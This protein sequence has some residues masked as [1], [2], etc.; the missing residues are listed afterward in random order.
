MFWKKEKARPQLKAAPELTSASPPSPVEPPE[1]SRVVFET[2]LDRA[3]CE[4]ACEGVHFYHA[5][6]L[7]N[8]LH[9][10][11]DWDISHDVS[12]YRLPDLRGKRVLDIGPASGWFSF[13]FEKL[14]ADVTVVETRGY[15][16]FDVYGEDRYT[17]AQGRPAD[18][19][20]DGR[21]IWF[22]PVSGSFWAM[23]DMLNSKVKFVNGRIYEVGPDLLPEPFDLV[24]VG[25]LLPH[26]RDP[27]GALRAARTVCKPDGLCI[28]TATT[29][30]AQDENPDP[31][32]M[33]P[34][35]SIDKISWWL[36][37]KAAY[38]HWFRAAGYRDVDVEDG[39]EY[40]PDREVFLDNGVRM[41]NPMKVRL[42][43][44]R[45]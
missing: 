10:P 25:A 45:P 38:S 3:A 34:Y 23:H 28:A 41:N 14:G 32:Q 16:D 24:F 12:R 8:G 26:L 22:G 43:H 31:V 39:L 4:A 13:Y 40:T 33:L 20:I 7:S 1:A 18:R 15:G 29:W 44:A 9:V 17:G 35:T 21:D 37:N 5:F 2:R 42:A 30:P 11:G 6:D 27:I 19:T 36:P